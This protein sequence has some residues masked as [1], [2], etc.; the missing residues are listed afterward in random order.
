[1]QMHRVFV[2]QDIRPAHLLEALFMDRVLANPALHIRTAHWPTDIPLEALPALVGPDRLVAC[3]K[4]WYGWRER[5]QV[6][7]YLTVGYGEAHAWVAAADVR[8]LDHEMT[9]LRAWLPECA[10]ED[11]HQVALRFWTWAGERAT[12][13]RRRLDLY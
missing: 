6:L 3:E 2:P 4:K 9:R 1:V 10:P 7:L 8:V 13:Y 5:D 12:S 11:P